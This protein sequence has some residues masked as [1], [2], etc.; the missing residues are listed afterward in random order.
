MSAEGHFKDNIDVGGV[1][2]V[3]VHFDDIGVVHEHLD[4]EFADKLLGD[5]FVL[6]QLLLDNLECAEELV[7]FLFGEEH[8]SV[9]SGAQLAD[10]HE[11]TECQP[12][13]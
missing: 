12:T 11:I 6:E 5:F 8:L 3:A 10:L 2:E 7:G 4:L 1:L 9:L 13:L